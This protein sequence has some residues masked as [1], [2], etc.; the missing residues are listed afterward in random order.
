M[1]IENANIQAVRME[2][3]QALIGYSISLLKKRRILVKAFIMIEFQQSFYMY[4]Y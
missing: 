1:T 2:S 4:L 3:S